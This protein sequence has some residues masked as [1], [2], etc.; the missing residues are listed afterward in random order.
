MAK[1]VLKVNDI[2][3]LRNQENVGLSRNMIV[4]GIPTLSPPGMNYWHFE[5]QGSGRNFYFDADVVI[6]LITSV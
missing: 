3:K 6:E 5:D 2:V 1:I 4:H